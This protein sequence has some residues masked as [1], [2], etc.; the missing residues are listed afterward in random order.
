M[1]L[2]EL[3][4]LEALSQDDFAQVLSMSIVREHSMLASD[5]LK[6]IVWPP[7]L[8]E[9]RVA[10]TPALEAVERAQASMQA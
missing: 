8:C 9:G 5:T 2:F 4:P 1:L 10:Y 7:T 3:F 6:G